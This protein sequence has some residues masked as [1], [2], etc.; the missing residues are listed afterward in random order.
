MSYEFSVLGKFDC[1]FCHVL[2][3]VE[4]GDYKQVELV[5]PHGVLC[6]NC[7]RTYWLDPAPKDP[8]S[9]EQNCDVK[10]GRMTHE[11]PTPKKKTKRR[12]PS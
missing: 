10:V 11:R 4:V 5:L 8:E 3:W 1:T 12:K 6:W 9:I 2:N 7:E